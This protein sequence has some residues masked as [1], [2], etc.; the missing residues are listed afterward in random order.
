MTSE[1][2]QVNQLKILCLQRRSVV[3]SR[4]PGHIGIQGNEAADRVARRA[5]TGDMEG[6]I[7]VLPVRTEI[8]AIATRT[9]AKRELRTHR[10]LAASS[11]PS[12]LGFPFTNLELIK[13]R[14]RSVIVSFISLACPNLIT[15]Q[16]AFLSK[17]YSSSSSSPLQAVLLFKQH[18]SPCNS[19]L[20]ASSSL[21][22]LGFSRYKF[23]VN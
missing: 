11:S 2:L 8:L 17:Q 15:T 4:V 16:A 18:S 23:R 14:M 5:A 19:P 20:Q 3:L 10:N 7:G 21:E 12:L 9:M 22:L 6:G 13:R 1:L